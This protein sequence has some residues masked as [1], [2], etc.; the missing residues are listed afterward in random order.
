MSP[1]EPV[2]QCIEMGCHAPGCSYV[3]LVYVEDQQQEVDRLR[4]ALERIHGHFIKGERNTDAP[5]AQ[6]LDK[7]R[8]QAAEALG[9]PTPTKDEVP[10]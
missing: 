5:A 6:T 3:N 8:I 2:F 1:T 4:A 9:L 10:R 7:I